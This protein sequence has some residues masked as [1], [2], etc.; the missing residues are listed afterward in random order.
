MNDMRLVAMVAGEEYQASSVLGAAMVGNP[1][2]DAV[3]GG[4]GEAERQQLE[5]MFLEMLKERPREVFVMKH[6]STIVGLL[7]SQECHGGPASQEQVAV[8]VDEV[9]IDDTESRIA[10]WLRIWDEHDPLESHRH[11]G[12]VGVLPEF[13]GRGIGS[14][15]M[16]HFCTQVDVNGEPAY[17]ETDKQENVGFYKKFRFELIGETDIFGV[18]NY[19]MWRPMT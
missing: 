13:Q 9:A 11:L 10:H 15:M 5:D 14:M 8:E 3:L 2:H 16:E 4:Q 7:R 1:I 12:P 19:F 6:E 17:L 18:K